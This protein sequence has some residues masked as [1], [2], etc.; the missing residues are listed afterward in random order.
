[1]NIEAYRSI[2]SESRLLIPDLAIV[3]VELKL[4]D[5]DGILTL[6]VSSPNYM[7]STIDLNALTNN[8][9]Y[10]MY[11]DQNLELTPPI[12]FDYYLSM[13]TN[14]NSLIKDIGSHINNPKAVLTSAGNPTVF[15]HIYKNKD[16]AV[17]IFDP[18]IVVTHSDIKIQETQQ[19]SDAVLIRAKYPEYDLK[20]QLIHL[21]KRLTT[22]LDPNMSIGYLDVQNDILLDFMM[23]MLEENPDLYTKYLA[24]FP[25][26]DSLKT[27]ILDTSLLST[28]S[29]D[30]CIEEIVSAKGRVREIQKKYYDEKAKIIKE[31]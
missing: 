23:F 15:I 31:F 3:K 26:L 7:E 30:A 18:V 10:R 9:L 5:T 20:R 16:D 24:R 6:I 1:M 8:T 17:I 19:S 13:R 21:K 29:G 25:K 2:A 22:Q 14:V 11:I 28:K 12:D 4:T 27:T